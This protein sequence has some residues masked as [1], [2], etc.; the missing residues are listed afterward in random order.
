MRELALGGTAVGTG[1]NT[2]KDFA[3]KAISEISAI[4]GQEFIE[5]PN[6]FEAQA[7]R[8]AAVSLSGQLKTL[9]TALMKIAEDLRW[10]ASGPRCGL[11]EI[12]LPE[13]QPGSSIMPAKV[14]P[15]ISESTMMV[16]AQV[17]G[18][19][20]AISLGGQRGNFELNVMLPMIAY[21]LNQSINILTTASENLVEKCLA[22]VTANIEKCAELSLIHI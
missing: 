3:G 14:N 2:T 1:L 4:V 12:N 15:V 13:I 5:A 17:F 7:A 19:D 21:N 22:G 10:L 18:N 16:S 6:H 11:G 9:A 20:L 8:D